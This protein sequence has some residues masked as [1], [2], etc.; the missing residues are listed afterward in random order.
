MD[1]FSA[2]DQGY[3]VWAYFITNTVTRIAYLRESSFDNAGVAGFFT[4]NWPGAVWKG[5]YKDDSDGTYRWD[6]SKDGAFAYG[7]S[8]GETI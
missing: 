4:S 3:T 5:P 7:A 1:P 8:L 2:A 6:G